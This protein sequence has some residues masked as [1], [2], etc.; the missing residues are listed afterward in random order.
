MG[1]EKVKPDINGGA[2][3]SRWA[4]REIVKEAAKKLRRR[5]SKTVIK[6]Q[7]NES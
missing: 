5:V 1:L 6:E 3:S 4:G 7:S 2:G